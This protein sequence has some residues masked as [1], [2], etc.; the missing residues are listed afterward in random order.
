M[1][2]K[3]E[4][5][6]FTLVA[7]AFVTVAGMGIGSLFTGME[8]VGVTCATGMCALIGY[9]VKQETTRPSDKPAI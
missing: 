5:K 4:S 2:K 7:C 6:R 8:A 1:G 3:F 9:Y